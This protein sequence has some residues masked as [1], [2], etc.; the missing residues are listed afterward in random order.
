MNKHLH[1]QPLSL[2]EQIIMSN[3]EEVLNNDRSFIPYD[4]MGDYSVFSHQL[5]REEDSP[6]EDQDRKKSQ[7]E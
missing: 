5:A 2:E 3:M 4:A 1:S 6:C 7:N